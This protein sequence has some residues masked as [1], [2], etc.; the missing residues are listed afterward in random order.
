MTITLEQLDATELKETLSRL[1]E[2]P[3]SVHDFAGVIENSKRILF[4]VNRQISDLKE[5]SA[6]I[7][8]VYAA[9]LRGDRASLNDRDKEELID[10][11]DA[12]E[13]WSNVEDSIRWYTEAAARWDARVSR[14]QRDYE[15]SKLEFEARLRDEFTRELNQMSND[16][17]VNL[18]GVLKR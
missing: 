8:A 18:S 12:D 10:V 1:P 15:I 2:I 5:T 6:N 11:L 3:E 9:K 14:L 16:L 13:N 4:L 17:T 7:K